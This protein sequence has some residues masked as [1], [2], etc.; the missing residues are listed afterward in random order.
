MRLA[1]AYLQT[2]AGGSGD[3]ELDQWIEA[4]GASKIFWGFCPESHC[5]ARRTMEQGVQ[6]IK[7]KGLGGYHLW[8][9]NSDNHDAEIGALGEAT[10]LVKDSSP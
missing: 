8:R 3:E 5:S 6:I 2:Y 9:I 4:A 1:M 10:R 7:D